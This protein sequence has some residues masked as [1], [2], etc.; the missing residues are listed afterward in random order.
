FASWGASPEE[1][2]A[3]INV[4]NV[5]GETRKLDIKV[6]RTKRVL[7]VD[8]EAFL[9][10][11]P[12]FG[13]L[14]FRASLEALPHWLRVVAEAEKQVSAM[15]TCD[16]QREECPSF[17]LKWQ[18]MRREA[19]DLPPMKKMKKVNAF[20]NRWPYRLDSDIYGRA[21]YWATPREF[22]TLSGD[23]EDYAIAKYF[24]LRQL[25]FEPE[26]LRI[27]VVMDTIRNLPHAVLV[28]YES[29]EAYLLDN[30]SDL[31]LPHTRYMHYQPQ[32]SVNESYRWMHVRPD[33]QMKE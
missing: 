12:L 31:V 27:V 7:K 26:A 23:C 6:V 14:E 15:T 19:M 4:L 21:D 30:L 10:E 24:A 22:L 9:P 5:E 11:I 25:G 32:Y 3:D 2:N 8:E 18:S 17:A 1:E 20:I 13:T 16:P 28:V 33:A 29:G